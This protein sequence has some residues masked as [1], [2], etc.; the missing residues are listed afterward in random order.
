[1]TT[2]LA[3]PDD[4]RT[5]GLPDATAA[6]GPAA[7]VTPLRPAADPGLP[8][9]PPPAGNGAARRPPVARRLLG[10]VTR[11][12]DVV[13]RAVADRHGERWPVL[14]TTYDAA[15]I[16]RRMQR[17]LGYR[18]DLRNP[19]TYNEKL[20]WRIL[21]DDNPLIPLTTDK[22]AVRDHVAATVGPEL[23]I[24]LIGTYERAVDIPWDD[25]PQSFVLKGSHGCAM[26]LLVPDKDAI[27]RSEVLRTAEGWLRTNYYEQSRERAYKQIPPRLLIEELLT[28]EDGDV[29]ADYKFL[30]F[31]GRTAL[32]RVHSGR[33]GDHRVNFFDADLQPVALRQIMPT[34]PALVLPP[35]VRDMIPVAEQLAADFDY[36]R[37]DLYWARG[38]CWFGEITHNDGNAH[39]FFEPA[40]YDA[41]LGALWRLPR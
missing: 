2:H 4:V 23:L 3:T 26:N 39:V 29:P 18:P 41:D 38:R 33:F 7:A 27:D 6:D 1:M 15:V 5:S 16:R 28:D 19:R 10:A 20:A 12:L 13:A 36:A 25:L 8:T 32:I 40:S 21:H 30:V 17:S 34:A 14:A 35:E 24:P 31:H 37:I 9:A 11:R 22:I